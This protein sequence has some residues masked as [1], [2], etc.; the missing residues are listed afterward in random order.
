[1][2]QFFTN[3]NRINLNCNE[4][5]E[6]FMNDV[7]MGKRCKE[8]LNVQIETKKKKNETKKMWMQIILLLQKQFKQRIFY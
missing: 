6:I 2:D 3:K 8:N 7:I 1:M 4:T 5:I